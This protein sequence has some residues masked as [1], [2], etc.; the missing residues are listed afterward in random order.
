MI[1][2]LRVRLTIDQSQLRPELHEAALTAK[3]ERVLP[4]IAVVVAS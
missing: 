1:V 2:L 3:Y 4:V